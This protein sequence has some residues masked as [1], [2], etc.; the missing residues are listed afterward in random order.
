LRDVTLTIKQSERE[1]VR[2]RCACNK[3]F[4]I[5]NAIGLMMHYDIARSLEKSRP[6][7]LFY[8]V[9]ARLFLYGIFYICCRRRRLMENIYERMPL[10]SDEMI[11]ISHKS[12]FYTY[13]CVYL[14]ITREISLG[15]CLHFCHF[16][17]NMLM[18]AEG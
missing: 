18:I 17:S 14:H 4:N 3:Q 12:L 13:S 16:A 5:S 15:H 1:R 8:C 7:P 9:R 2:E 6:P 11:F 10:C